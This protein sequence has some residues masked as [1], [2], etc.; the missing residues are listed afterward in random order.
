MTETPQTAKPS[1]A[2]PYPADLESW[3]LEQAQRHFNLRDPKTTAKRLVDSAGILSDLFT[4]HRSEKFAEAYTGRLPVIAYGNYFFPQTYI[5]TRFVLSEWLGYREGGPAVPSGPL[6]ILD[7]GGGSGAALVSAADSLHARFPGLRLESAIV[8]A[9]PDNLKAFRQLAQDRRPRTLS[10]ARALQGD[11]RDAS[12]WKNEK[13]DLI[14]AS[15]SL[16]EAFHQAPDSEFLAWVETVIG[17]LAKNGLLVL[18]EPALRETS[19]R[20]ERLRDAI[21]SQTAHGILGPC[22][23]REACPLL[24]GKKFWCHDARAW[25][26]PPMVQRINAVLNRTLWDLKYS[27]LLLGKEGFAPSHPSANLFR[28]T[29]SFTKEKGK[30]SA[31]GC[32]ADGGNPRY[33]ILRNHIDPLELRTLEKFE[34]GDILQ[35]E[36]LRAL[37]ESRLFRIENPA[38]LKALFKTRE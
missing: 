23:H 6:R 25:Q 27:F 3:W 31:T 29:S 36:S 13:W 28:L 1:S 32:A 33:E 21:A 22:Q 18:I 24:A 14:L 5:R 10:H 2:D 26:V 8:D 19:E 12:L 9:S 30:L 38:G 34:R 16:N 4:T 15:F 11:L 20:L 37:G 7:L 17:S 35:A